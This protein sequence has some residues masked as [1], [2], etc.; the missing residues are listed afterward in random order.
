[1]TDLWKWNN[2]YESGCGP[3]CEEEWMTTFMITEL[4]HGFQNAARENKHFVLSSLPLLMALIWSMFM[5]F[6]GRK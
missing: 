5:K 3:C 1:M 4:E 2:K 6:V